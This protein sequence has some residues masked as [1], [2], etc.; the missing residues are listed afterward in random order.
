MTEQKKIQA[1]KD[2]RPNRIISYEESMRFL[3]KALVKHR[4]LFDLLRISEM[5]VPSLDAI[6]AYNEAITGECPDVARSSRAQSCF[7]TYD[8]YDTIEE[9]IACITGLLVKNHYFV[10]GNK[11]TAAFT[12]CICA[13]L[14]A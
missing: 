4:R 3:E 8:Y 5:N 6:L 7:S 14:T 11:R 13:R 9:K 10:D 2:K 1:T 12:F